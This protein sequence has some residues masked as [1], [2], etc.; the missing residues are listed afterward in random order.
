[1]LCFTKTILFSFILLT[2][3]AS[4]YDF[5]YF[6]QEWSPAA[7]VT[8]NCRKPNSQVPNVLGLFPHFLDGSWPTYCNTSAKFEE[9]EIDD[10]KDMLHKR[11]VGQ[12]RHNAVGDNDVFL[13]EDLWLMHGTCTRFTQ[14]DYFFM[15]L[16]L[17]LKYD[18]KDALEKHDILPSNDRL[19][20]TK[21]IQSAIKKE[22]GAAPQLECHGRDLTK[23]WIC[24]NDSLQSIECPIVIPQSCDNLISFRA[25]SRS[26]DATFTFQRALGLEHAPYW[27]SHW[28]IPSA[29]T[30]IVL[31]NV[32]LAYKI[33]KEYFQRRKQAT[34]SEQDLERVKILD[35]KV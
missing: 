15:T 24:L 25:S 7:C 10:M 5:L 20:K 11:I 21:Q 9:A 23:V 6:A 26:Q 18:F 32:M 8:E 22:T 28:L 13:W 1:M 35:M 29:F 12:Y 14:T 30:L 27:V 4:A 19:Y 17:A 2:T 31:T 34:K 33:S 3:F 16:Q